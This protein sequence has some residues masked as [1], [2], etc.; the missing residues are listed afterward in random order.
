MF[1][2]YLMV[3][4]NINSNALEI[5]LLTIQSFIV[6]VRPKFLIYVVSVILWT[7]GLKGLNRH[8]KKLLEF[9]PCP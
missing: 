3:K 7:L 1:E 5:I 8:L 4:H 6:V 9:E 2:V